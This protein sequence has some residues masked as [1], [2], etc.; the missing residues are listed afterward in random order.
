[1]VREQ[2]VVALRDAGYRVVD[3][4]TSGVPTV[5]VDIQQF[6]SWLNPGFFAVTVSTV[7]ATDIKVAGRA[8]PVTVRVTNQESALAVTDGAWIEAIDKTMAKWRAEVL[9]RKVE[10]P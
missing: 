9:A 3:A 8:A 10:M 1:M 6:W 4:G 7:V 2:L 5:D